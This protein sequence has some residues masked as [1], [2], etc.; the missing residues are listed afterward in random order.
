MQEEE[1]EPMDK[2][3]EDEETG[4]EVDD[5]VSQGYVEDKEEEG[6]EDEAGLNDADLEEEEEEE[7]EEA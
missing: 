4:H 2:G 1:R 6:L 3:F 7:G 5:R